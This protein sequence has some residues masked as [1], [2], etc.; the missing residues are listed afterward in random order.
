MP[1]SRR[2]F[3]SRENLKFRGH[4]GRS[5]ANH[6]T[7]GIAASGPIFDGAGSHTFLVLDRAHRAS[8]NFPSHRRLGR[9]PSSRSDGDV[10]ATQPRATSQQ[11]VSASETC[12]TSLGEDDVE[13]AS[14]FGILVRDRLS[15]EDITAKFEQDCLARALKQRACTFSEIGRSERP[16]R[17]RAARLLHFDAATRRPIG[18]TVLLQIGT[19]PRFHI[20]ICTE[21]RNCECDHSSTRGGDCEAR[22]TRDGI[23]PRATEED[24]PC[25]HVRTTSSQLPSPSSRRPRPPPAWS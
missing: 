24:R 19:R 6:A 5:L 20:C 12:S 16:A 11:R 18:G 21:S 17:V 7:V 10:F 15:P 4:P 14:E 22:S 1:G 3:F 13:R 2:A 23:D 8:A 25:L 9:Q